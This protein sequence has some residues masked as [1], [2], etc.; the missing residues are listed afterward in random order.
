VIT[1]HSKVNS[2]K[3]FQKDFPDV[4]DWMPSKSRPSGSFVTNYVSGAMSTGQRNQNLWR[5]GEL[6]D[7]ERAILANVR[8]LSEGVDV[9]ALDGVAF[10]DPRNS[11]IDIVQAVGRA[12]R[13]SSAKDI[14]TIIIPVFIRDYEDADEVLNESVF[15]KVW[16]VVNALRSH[17]EGLG[18]ELDNLRKVLGKRGSVG[19]SVKIHF[20]LP[21]QISVAFEKSLSIRLIESTT[22]SWEYWYGVLEHYYEK[23]GDCLVPAG[24]QYKGIN[25]G[26]W[27]GTQRK[28]KS[29]MSSKRKALLEE[30]GFVWDPLQKQWEYGF[31]VLKEYKRK[32]GNCA[33]SGDLYYR[34][35]N[36]GT[37]VSTQRFGKKRLEKSKVRLLDSLGF[38]W[39]ALEHQ[40]EQGFAALIAYKEEYGNCLVGIKV[41]YNEIDL[42]TWMAIQRKNKNKIDEK[43][44]RRLDE[45]GF[46]WEH[47]KGKWEQ[48]FD[49]LKAYKEQYGDCLVPKGFEYKGIKLGRWVSL[50]REG[51]HKLQ[52]E[53][54]TRLEELGFLWTPNTHQ[55]EQ[56]FTAL[57]AYKKEF[58]DCLVPLK[59]EYA[60]IKLGN[61]VINQR[62]QKSTM[63]K[64]RIDRL[65]GLGFIWDA[66]EEQWEQSFDALK[67]YRRQYGDCLVPRA[68]IYEKK[69]LGNWVRSQRLKKS[70]LSK[71]K[72]A[73]LDSLGFVWEL[74]SKKRS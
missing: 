67:A 45:I 3:E 73:R 69:R 66:L 51:K 38:I 53:E 18:I 44:R 54:I 4:V 27:V 64:D 11:E 13:H 24:K 48:S 68:I 35:M 33:V 30:L 36:L 46:V 52:D 63:S 7:G 8:C 10:I 16:A 15:K 72:I 56:A 19:Q 59:K 12:I 57:A 2:A 14:G 37:W 41:K 17:D 40:W 28:E 26:N 47:K 55:W 43:R 42:G 25:L 23:H 20:D 62:Q 9:P 29:T 60:G 49:A 70:R 50:L 74:A 31:S 22:A 32:F 5:L 1:F 65:D 58:G 61:W 39:N 71:E 6:E 21:T 34:G